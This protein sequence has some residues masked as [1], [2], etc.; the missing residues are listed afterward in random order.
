M[1]EAAECAGMSATEFML[2][3]AESS[4]AGEVATMKSAGAIE[5]VAIDEN[6]AV[7]DVGPVVEN[8]PVIMPIVSPASPAPAKPTEEADPKA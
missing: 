1:I 2:R 5:G 4:C 3:P 8:D 7:G 6:S